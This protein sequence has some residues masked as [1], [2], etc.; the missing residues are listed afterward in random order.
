[1]NFDLES[2]YSHPGTKWS[3]YYSL[4][5]QVAASSVVTVPVVAVPVVTTGCE[6]TNANAG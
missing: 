6:I 5:Y 4:Q 2:E 1:M 3:Q